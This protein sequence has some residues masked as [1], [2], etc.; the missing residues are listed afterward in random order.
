MTCDKEGFYKDLQA[1]HFMS[2]RHKSTRWEEKNVHVQCAG[3]NLFGAGK[4]WEFGQ[5][6]NELYGK[7]TAEEMTALSKTTKKHS[8]AD[9]EE[10][11]ET[12]KKKSKELL[13]LLDETNT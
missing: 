11:L 10:L 7:G 12:Y 2:R 9:L 6:L 3:C 5:A 8:I 1:G 13:D 4:Q